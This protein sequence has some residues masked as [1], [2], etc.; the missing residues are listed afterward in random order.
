VAPFAK[1]YLFIYVLDIVTVV[2]NHALPM[3]LRLVIWLGTKVWRRGEVNETMHFLLD[4]PRRYAFVL[5]RYGY[6]TD[7][8]DASFT[9]SR[10]IKR[11]T[12]S[13]SLSRS[14]M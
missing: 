5:P 11:G 14:R 12:L 2:G 10:V 4:H 6:L 1:C 3:T 13:S 8:S 9:S 7:C